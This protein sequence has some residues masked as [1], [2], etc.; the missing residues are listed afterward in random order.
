[1]LVIFYKYHYFT[2]NDD[3]NLGLTTKTTPFAKPQPTIGENTVGVGPKMPITKKKHLDLIDF[4][5]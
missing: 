5:L 3:N 4:S 2:K 1:M